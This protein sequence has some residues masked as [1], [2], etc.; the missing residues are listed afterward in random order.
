MTLITSSSTQF[1]KLLQLQTSSLDQVSSIKKLMELSQESQ[2]Q[3]NVSGEGD[4]TYKVQVEQLEQVKEQLKASR[5]F[6][7]TQAEFEKEWREESKN[8]AKLAEGINAFKTTTGL[9]ANVLKSLNF[10]GIFNKALAKD[11]FI[12]KQR[13]LGAGKEISNK[14]LGA[15]F[16]SARKA[17][18][19][20][21]GVDKEL[22]VIKQRTGITDEE[23]LR[24]MSPKAA[25]LM[26]QRNK[27][28]DTY[29]KY[30]RA[31]D[32]FSPT[33]VSRNVGPAPM[34]NLEQKSPTQQ[35]AD[36]GVQ[37]ERDNEAVKKSE[38]NYKLL[39]K[40]EEN[41]RGANPEQKLKPSEDKGGGL[42]A[43]LMGG[44]KMSGALEGMKKFGIGLIAISSALWIASKAFANFGELDWDS[45]GKGMVALGGLVLAAVALDKVKGQII[46]GALALGAL[47]LVTWGISEAFKTFSDLDWETIGKGFLA[48]AGIGVIGAIAGS[49]APMILMGALALGALGAS[50]YVIGLAME[51]VGEG[52]NSFVDGLERLGKVDASNLGGIAI[53]IAS[54]GAAMAAFGA[55]QAAA[56]LGNLVSRFLTIGTDSPVETL[57]KIGERGQGIEQAATGLNNI[58]EAMAKFANIDKKSMEAINEF[59]W[60]KATAFVA[61]GG[62]MSVDGGKVYNSSKQNADDGATAGAG[63]G[64][65]TN[66]VNA[67]VTTNSNTTQLIR[68]PI[69]NQESSQQRYVLSKI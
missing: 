49:A 39:T 68:S 43:G 11:E 61:A 29:A 25:S 62:A 57:L 27:H 10:G 30:D 7:K 16:E 35:H 2:K 4:R 17:Q 22:N 31:A 24:Q 37:E 19:N 44:G 34:T 12:K 45:I 41:T 42:M 8:I 58:G 15:D 23:K 69:R 3:K 53:A 32:Q 36:A 47:A 59:P 64:S 56:G 13:D 38:E 5:S 1:G 54:L 6:Y 55:G 65:N 14:Q 26:D 20:I 48:I 60:L 18:K 28:T 40:I 66:V 46:Q 9:K 51:K 21:K 67:P 52:I 50:V 63:G 33:P